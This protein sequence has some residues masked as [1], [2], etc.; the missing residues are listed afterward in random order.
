M[1]DHCALEKFKLCCRNR[2]A[3]NDDGDM[4]GVANSRFQ[5]PVGPCILRCGVQ[6]ASLQLG[7]YFPVSS[8]SDDRDCP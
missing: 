5:R 7:V 2:Y 1:D 4:G 6:P 8:T 3:T